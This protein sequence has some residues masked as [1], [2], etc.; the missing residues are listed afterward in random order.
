MRLGKSRI[1]EWLGINPRKLCLFVV[2][3]L[4]LEPFTSIPAS[5]QSTT[6]NAGQ[7]I[8]ALANVPGL[9]TL[10]VSDV[11]T[12]QNSGTTTASL[13]VK[14]VEST[15]I[16]FSVG[17]NPA[18][19]IIPQ[20]FDL[21]TFVPL[22]TG[23]PLDQVSFDS[24]A[25]IFIGQGNG[26]SGVSKSN[27][28]QALSASL[29]GVG[30]TLDLKAGINLYG[31]GSVSGGAIGELLSAAGASS[32]NLPFNTALPANLFA[33]DAGATTD[34]A[35][36]ASAKILAQVLDN[37]QLQA[38]IPSVDLKSM[39]GS[40]SFKD[41][42]LGIK[43]S[44]NAQG[45]YLYDV[46]MTGELTADLKGADA[47]FN[48]Q[49]DLD[50]GTAATRELVITGTSKSTIK[51]SLFRPFDIKDM[52][53]AAK[54]RQDKW[55]VTI[56]GKSSINN[57]DIDVALH[58]AA[59]Q[60]GTTQPVY[61]IAV[62]TQLTVA[63]VAPELNMPGFSD[64]KLQNL[65]VRESLAD[66]RIKIRE[67]E[68]AIVY[69]RTAPNAKAQIAV[70]PDT[71]TLANFI[72]TL[73]ETP[74][75]SAKFE[76]MAVI[77]VPQGE[78]KTGV[79]VS[80]LE[81]SVADKL[82]AAGTSLNFKAGLNLFGSVDFPSSSDIGSLLT[83]V[84]MSSLKLPI[85]G[86]IDP[87]VFRS[88]GGEQIKN[89]VLENLD[90][91]MPLPAL[92]PPGMPN[93]VKFADKGFLHFDGSNTNGTRNFRFQ[94]KDGLS[95]SVAGKQ[96]TFDG[97]F[98]LE[99]TG[100][101]SAISLAAI[102][103]D[104]LS[105][106]GFTN[107][108]TKTLS[109]N[110]AK[111]DN[112]WDVS[113]AATA[114]LNSKELDLTAALST[115]GAGGGAAYDIIIDTKL[116]LADFVG[117]GF[118][119][120]GLSAIELEKL[121][122]TKD[123]AE[124]R[125]KVRDE[126]ANIAFYRT[127]SS[128]KMQIAV[129]PDAFTLATFIPPLA[130]TPLDSGVF[131]NMAFIWVPK[132]EASATAPT[133]IPADV[134]K[135]LTAGGPTHAF[136][137]GLNL[138]GTF[139]ASS[140]GQVGSLLSSLGV[141]DHTLPL[142][143]S[144]N[145]SLFAKGQESA[146][147]KEA[148][149]NNLNITAPL[150]VPKIPGAPDALTFK[151]AHFSVS[152]KQTG[153]TREV[154]VAVNGDIDVK[155][156]SKEIEFTFDVAAAKTA[157]TKTDLTI[158][159]DST[160]K[161]TL[162]FFEPLE[163]DG[164][165]LTATRSDNKW[166]SRVDAKSKLNNKDLEVVA[167]KTADGKDTVKITTKITLADLLPSGSSIPGLS[168]VEFDEVDFYT[169][170][171]EFTG[172]IKNLDTQVTAFKRG[173]GNKLH[174]GVTFG[175]F[176]VGS[177]VPAVAGSALDDATFDAMAFV[178]VPKGDGEKG[179]NATELPN[180]LG[181]VIAKSSAKIDL[182]PGLNLKGSLVIKSGTKVASL[183]SKAG[184]QSDSLPLTGSLSL[185]VFA[186]GTPSGGVKN[187]ILDA[188]NI[189]APV[190]LPKMSG[191]PVT[192][193]NAHFAIKGQ[194]KGGTRDIQVAVTGDID[195][196]LGA[197]E[198][199]FAFDIEA[200]KTQGGGTD[201]TIT[202]D[203]T[204]KVT[205]PFFQPLELDAMKLT[206]SRKGGKWD[207][208]VDATSKL[209]NKPLE[210]V[211]TKTADGK[212][213]VKITTKIT[214]ADLLPSGSSI[215]GLSDVEF[216]EV[217]FYT[218]FGEFT[219]KIKNLDT[220]VTA[221]KRGPGNKLHIGVTFGDF[222]VASFVP[223]VAGS[224]LDDA[225]FDAM[226]F[227]W[228]PKGDGE[229]AVKA[230]E[231]P[232]DLGTVISKSSANIDLNPGLNLKG[233][234]VIKSGT[235]IASLMSKVGIKSNS[236]P[237][238]GTL[239]P[240]V[241]AK[242]TP[243]GGVK[244]AIL[245]ALN[246][247]APLPLPSM[248][249]APVT[250]KNAHFAIKGENKDGTRDIK[251]AVTGA[252]D[253]KL[254]TKEIDFAFDVEADKT[255]GGGTDVTITADSTSKVTLPFF[256]PLELDAMKLTATRKDGKWSSYVDAKSKLNNKPLE[257]VV[258]R[259]PNPGEIV[260]I[261]TK[262]TLADL[263]PSGTSIPGLSDVEFDE[264]DFYEGYGEFTGKLKGLD[265][266][267]TA[268]KRGP[269]NKLH[270]GVTF[271]AFTV[272]SF[273]PAVAGSAIDDATFDD[274]AF[275]WVPK[276][277]GEKGVNASDLP[278]DL[279]T[280]ITKSSA[281]I[282]L[283]PG[284]NLKGSLVI[285]SGTKVASLMSKAGIKSNS[286][287]LTGSLSPQVFAKGTPSGGVKNAILDALNISAPVPLPS[288]SGAPV[289]FKNAH[290]AIKGEKKGDVRDILVAVTGAI[291]VSL[292]SKEIDFAFDIEADKTQGG[293]TDVTIKADSTSKVTL[294]FFE[295]LELDA[296]K[297]TAS[298]KDGKWDSFVDAT[299]KINNKPLEV[300]ATKTPDGKDTVKI[301]TKITLADLL[302]SG[303][304]IPGLSD[305]EFDEIDFYTGFAEFTGKIKKLDTQVTAFK[306]GPGNKLHIGV[307]FGAFSVGSFIP[308][309]SGTA[310][311]DA[312]FD[313]MAFVWVP[314][315]DGEKGVN[316]SDLPND[317]GTVITKSSAK[318]DLNPGLNLKGS[319]DIKS[320]TKIASLLGKLNIK[321]ASLPL[322][323][324]LSPEVFNKGAPSGGVKNAIIDALDISAPVPLPSMSGAPVSFKKA[325]FAIKGEKKGE[326]RDILVAVTGDIDVKVGSK[327]IEFAFDIEA[328]KTVG[329]GT[330]LTITADSTKKVTLSLFEP[331][332]LD[333]MNL[334]ATRTSGKWASHVDAKTKINNKEMDV[335][336]TKTEK[337]ESVKITSKI[338]LAD[339]MPGGTSVPGLSDV[340]I[341]ELDILP[342]YVEAQLKIKG[343]DTV[344]T[345]F[346]HGGKKYMATNIVKDFDIGSFIPAVKGTPLDDAKFEHMVFVWA[347]KTGAA[348]NLNPTDVPGSIGDQIK[349]TAEKFAFKPGVNVFGQ[350]VIASTSKVGKLLKH[351]GISKSSLP[352]KGALSPSVFGKVKGG[353]ATLKSKI[354]ANLDLNIP[355]P[356]INLPGVSKV[357]TIKH[358]K[359]SIKGVKE[360]VV[361]DVIGVL[362]VSV[363]SKTVAFDYKV[364]VKEAAGKP[365][366]VTISGKTVP[367]TKVTIKMM[368]T[369]TLSEMDFNMVKA[370]AG[371]GWS[372]AAQSHFKKPI[373]VSYNH[374][375]A[376]D[377]LLNI[378]TKMTAA[379]IVG[380]ANLPGLDDVEL[381]WIQVRNSFWRLGLT[382]KGISADIDL[383]KPSGSSKYQFSME[384]DDFSP[385]T[386][387]PDAGNSPLKD[388]TFKALNLVYSPTKT[389]RQVKLADL[390]PDIA[391][392]MRGTKEPVTLKPGLNVFGHLEVHPTGEVATLLKKIGV[393]KLTLPLNGK[394]S[395]K[396]FIK[397][398]SAADIKNDILDNLDLKIAIPT[399][400]IPEVS[401][402]LTFQNGHLR[403]KG[404]TPSGA[405][406]IDVG[407][408]G[409]TT[410]KVKSDSL[411]FFMDVEYDSPQGSSDKEWK[412]TGKTIHPW[413]HPVGIHWLD[414]TS[415]SI[416]IDE[417]KKSGTSTFDITVNAKTKV[418]SSSEMD[419]KVDVH[420][421]NGLITDAYF[422]MDG[423]IKLGEIPEINKIPEANKFTLTKL[424]VSEHGI[425]ADSMIAGRA[426][427]LFAFHGS[428][429]NLALTQ[430]D[431]AITEI[432]PPLKNTP[433][434]HIKFPFA[435]VML[436]EQGLNKPYSE[437]SKVGKDALKDIYS[438]PSES[439]NIKPGVAF[440]AGFHPDHAGPMGKTVKGIGV[441]TEVLVMGEVTGIFG[442][443]DTPKVTLLGKLSE[444]GSN[445]LPGFM[446]MSKSADLDFFIT[447][448]PDEFDLGLQVG[449]NTTIKG[450]KL[451]FDAKVQV[452]VLD[453]GFGL[454]VLGQMKG[455]WH[456]PFGIPGFSLGNVTVELGTEDGGLKLGFGGSTT[457]ANDTFTMAG[458]VVISEAL[459]PEA[460]AFKATAT[461]IPMDFIEEVALNMLAKKIHFDLP[462]GIMPTFKGIKASPARNGYPATK[463]T[464]GVLFA[465]VSPGAQDA[466]LG[467]TSEGF[468][469][470]GSLNW[471]GHEL[472]EM[473]LSVSPTKGLYA[474]GSIDNFKMGPI[475]LEEN[476]FLMEASPTKFPLLKINSK[477]DIIGI[478][479][480]FD[481]VF[482]SSEIKIHAKGS[483][484]KDITA[485][486]TL[487][488]TGLDLDKAK[489]DM[490]KADFFIDGKF[491]LDIPAFIEG[492][493]KKAMNEAFNE[494]GKG[495]KKGLKAVKKAQK[496]VDHLTTKINEER[497]KVRRE[498]AAAERG[499]HSAENRVNSLNGSIDHDWHKYHHCHGWKK[500]F[501][502]ARWGI[503]ARFEEGLRDVADEALRLAETLVAHFPLDLD[504]RVAFYIVERDTAKGVLYIA[505]KAIEGLDDLDSIME[506]ALDKFADALGKAADID[507]KKAEFKGDLRGVITKDEPVDLTLDADLFGLNIHEQFSFKIKDLGYDVEQL[508][509]MGLYALDHLFE[510]VMKHLP[511][512]FKRHVQAVIG[513]KIDAKQASQKQELA[514]YSKDFK[515]YN[516]QG[517]AIT[518]RYKAYNAAYVK[519]QIAIK[520]SGLDHDPVSLK[521]KN[522]YIEVGHTGLCLANQNGFI[523]QLPCNNKD[524]ENQKWST[525][526]AFGA[527]SVKEARGF[528][529][530]T[531]GSN[532]IS[533]DGKWSTVQK[534]FDNFSFPF[535]VFKGDNKLKVGGCNNA[536]QYYWKVQKHGDGWMQLA[537]R[538]NDQC[539]HFYDSNGVP[540]KAKAEWAPCVGSANQVFRVA[541]STSPKYHKAKVAFRS[542]TSGLCFSDA[543]K[544]DDPV[545][546]VNCRGGNVALYDYLVDIEGRVKF[547]NTRTGRCLQP[548][549]YKTGVDL[550]EAVCTQ[551][552]Y[553]WWG[554]IQVPGGWKIKNAQTGFCT[555]QEY[556]VKGAP[557][558]QGSCE[559]WSLNVFAP[560]TAY[561][562]G[563][564]WKGSSFRESIP[565]HSKFDAAYT[566]AERMPA[567]TLKK[568]AEER[569]QLAKLKNDANWA[570]RN[571]KNGCTPSQN[572]EHAYWER[573]KR[574][575]HGWGRFADIARA[576]VEIEIINEQCRRH[577]AWEARNNASM[578]ARI[579]SDDYNIEIMRA[580]LARNAVPAPEPKWYLCRGYNGLHQA[581]VPGVVVN[582]KCVYSE[583]F[584]GTM[585][586]EPVY[587]I[588]MEGVGVVWVKNVGGHLPGNAIP[589]GFWQKPWP[590]TAYSC[591]TMVNDKTK[592]GW[593]W[594]GQY[595]RYNHLGNYALSSNFEVLSRADY[596]VDMLDLTN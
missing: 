42:V 115:G 448:D 48:V 320:G 534:K 61:D 191:A 349:F 28:P 396:T 466:S 339:L 150:P 168:D 49:L 507:I 356:K 479:E 34:D 128:G 302:P 336:V 519:E 458:D 197:K 117:G 107:F 227:V 22:P 540:E 381:D 465:F 104:S 77:W 332:E 500:A 169:G 423:P 543:S 383:I 206:A 3:A 60:T 9:G 346:R 589:T 67:A 558:A 106:P 38:P 369:F 177:F 158:T 469:M 385:A 551:L 492:P 365:V 555:E 387:I 219:G 163:L 53:I 475:D 588:L 182:N 580:K 127:S 411:A 230:S 267:V 164:M 253:V 413:N 289:K 179:I 523:V 41:G 269:G 87:A 266:Q 134:D 468:G 237:L 494:M 318:I 259:K 258:T 173:P 308:Q 240:Q 286:L 189:S 517:K 392:K 190:P 120:P 324:T 590:A 225:T 109:L 21:K 218:G 162:P 32:S 31:T 228:V 400:H 464:K 487:D 167:T 116:T 587:D 296:M 568:H 299:S 491:T 531:Q 577:E 54:G 79:Q 47:V 354:L 59:G 429:W 583:P 14:G 515:G 521:L 129:M 265:T 380:D 58:V 275:V 125:I 563:T 508:G 73:S 196:K 435:A 244:N 214:L 414:L 144:I 78:A 477:I 200:D 273:V 300:V 108:E 364:E 460:V 384:I 389:T 139:A 359:L 496:K 224:A 473:K 94:V 510:K 229:K 352:L 379:E 363:H 121:E 246:I 382:L 524:A 70:L 292:G 586:K 194:N 149:L 110:A 372:V 208:F 454:E 529:Y 553:Q 72:P 155:L 362:D 90:L 370:K 351:V 353:S 255:Q 294:P 566:V 76:S 437:L 26:A 474:Q 361:V 146:Q 156:A 388:V 452:Q 88:G 503:A 330:N 71:F 545:H 236:L 145:P 242:G 459:V 550:S 417:K 513:R 584:Q 11:N 462:Q 30:D 175:D 317:L 527:D 561:S 374:T 407:I 210:V 184:I 80:G 433:L 506:R 574:D 378:S 84:G 347:S 66:A 591:R 533:M 408:S 509:L 89:A 114:E 99:K 447:V 64:V 581:W 522:E 50:Q 272:G 520:M 482:D 443:S 131:S 193:K 537:N 226:A 559:N 420:E 418:G 358:S 281:K 270:I 401:K 579:R 576:D 98:L 154:D 486:F 187:A 102:T 497:A 368:E 4:I 518:A 27:L 185:Q 157:G 142:S 130:G 262:I 51:I 232:N 19:A 132:G 556:W 23:T 488:L 416:D 17:N 282:D 160:S 119:A 478:K 395:P 471:L 165:S 391:W 582:R 140:S 484:S 450:D 221:F 234:L 530:L 315:G 113:L 373:D 257:V 260:K 301:T 52:A 334:T 313:N 490:K 13:T 472:G 578:R 192:F 316:A 412:F 394:F 306:R 213:T 399:P 280:V 569:T 276:G 256:Q 511:H 575:A 138:F 238:T 501:C 446:K 295:P 203:S 541:D 216:D 283:N 211:A 207:S 241:F 355:L 274:M 271:G 485:D 263:L 426:T 461:E 204:S 344:I 195:V 547:I 123:W 91:T 481:V 544:A 360:A 409:D 476:K 512:G 250:F 148:I 328:D 43:T 456:K 92:K 159:A 594:K 403:I 305:V 209:N 557:V 451:L 198:I 7:A 397:N 331:M 321:S 367:G 432:I 287:P 327:D 376:G 56:N 5:A 105:F 97:S 12:D 309:V 68:A 202:A 428:G 62:S 297:L 424:I 81:K 36:A 86:S 124:T 415:L 278:N 453:D 284:L 499:L 442:G 449:V 172:K 386:F 366:E 178:W 35:Q 312:T 245:D 371:W 329:G 565:L 319:L 183:L 539:L 25:F 304:S 176:S 342:G 421:T 239:S 141:S 526:P 489:I 247:S 560:T 298:R 268:F 402:F 2:L 205:L 375:A 425:E 430:K 118:N 46:A 235:K 434:K 438:N 398:H 248:A 322:T 63:D 223:A 325:H 552:D 249:G 55:D 340:E 44:K 6:Q 393:S 181:T 333:S 516:K 548:H 493:A 470:H 311:D 404:K 532:C 33:Y 467:L 483:F 166:A 83:Q 585:I 285:K 74:L 18:A 186:K 261:T 441:K 377:K 233:S 252:M 293:G 29:S 350:M 133:N 101:Q 498:R 463:G 455:K 419:V 201:V 170:F 10:S 215:P 571:V 147:I 264:I 335:L 562:Y 535:P 345:A 596:T 445:S 567:Y 542:D 20:Q 100:Q 8:P 279:G 431:F 277:D 93:F 15:A 572:S 174:I 65:V 573:S 592:I 95:V 422:E 1:G 103:K 504:P 410:V 96:A 406:G 254:G 39:P 188:L 45:T 310:L 326:T 348:S 390:G 337:S 57:K 75:E 153:S 40:K 546:L 595:C 436:S 122:I 440:V 82:K 514:K 143:G 341:D 231:L 343:M 290:F 538:A 480:K 323:G 37:L 303:S 16:G 251:V 564:Y 427:D 444:G 112:A 314:K 220:Q 528:V 135:V 126:E 222:T 439:I 505:E 24:I 217:D 137:E 111:K 502:K 152:T 554:A 457:L 212:Y 593:T 405:R 180:D 357:A 69:Y 291:D 495:L 338:T 288:M 536:T 199:E 307:T 161:V 171:G 151:N 136:K 243:S 549:D 570:A 525:T 85:R